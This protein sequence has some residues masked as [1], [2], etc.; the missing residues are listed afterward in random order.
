MKLLR[1]AMIFALGITV[2]ASATAATWEID[3]VH[4]T[5]G[6]K[7]R[8]FF[9]KQAGV[10]NDFSGTI[11]FDPENP[12]TAQISAT[13]VVLSIITNNENRDNHLRSA[14]FFDAETHPTITFVSTKVEKEGQM[15]M[16]T[17]DLTIRGI[18]KTV[19][20]PVEF[21]GSGPDA[22]GGTRAGFSAVLEVNRKD[23]EISWNNTLDTGGTV[24][25][26]VVTIS[27]EIE[28]AQ[29]ATPTEG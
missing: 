21:H 12:E 25:G 9:A 5:V 28:A 16:M 18:T 14:D 10:F 3:P 8:H 20:V 29:A 26:D 7:V 22:W 23:F 13:I 19:R 27:L 1:F 17:G 11:V 2:V 6:F 24:L 4:S 15:F